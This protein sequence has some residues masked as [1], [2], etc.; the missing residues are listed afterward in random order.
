M[1]CGDG[2]V[3]FHLWFHCVPEPFG[4][5]QNLSVIKT[6]T[7]AGHDVAQQNIIL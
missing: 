5:K 6:I 4:E 1:E 2:D 3:C 7:L